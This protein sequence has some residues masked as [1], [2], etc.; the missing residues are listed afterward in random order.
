MSTAVTPISHYFVWV[1][2]D[3]DRRAYEI[4]QKLYEKEK[5][6]GKITDA[7]LWGVPEVLPLVPLK[8][9]A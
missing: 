7:L 5:I 3:T 6:M 2:L 9:F 4:S 8:V 1:R